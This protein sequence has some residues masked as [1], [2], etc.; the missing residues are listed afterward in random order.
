MAPRSSES[1]RALIVNSI[2][3][4]PETATRSADPD[5]YV[6]ALDAVCRALAEHLVGVFDVDRG[7]P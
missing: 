4:M 2:Q 6:A 1:T 3:P 5:A 7:D